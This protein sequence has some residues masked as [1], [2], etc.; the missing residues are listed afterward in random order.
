MAG[1]GFVKLWRDILESYLFELPPSHL[2][3]ALACISMANWEPVEHWD[4]STK[5]V[6]PRG[7]F[8]VDT[9]KLAERL[10]LGRQAVRCALN[11][12]TKGGFTTQHTTRRLMI[13]SLVNY[14][15]YQGREERGN[16]ACNPTKTREATR[17]QPEPQLGLM[18]YQ[19]LAVGP[20]L[21]LSG[22][23]RSKEERNVEGALDPVGSR[24]SDQLRNHLLSQQP[25]HALRKP[26]RW[27]KTRRVWSRALA[28]IA[29]E[30]GE[31]AITS[32]LA[33][34]FGDQGGRTE[35]RF[36]VD[37]PKA[38]GEKWD[39]IELAMRAPAPRANGQRAAPHR[40]QPKL[41]EDWGR[42]PAATAGK[43]NR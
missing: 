42:D 9:R 26:E 3:V 8:V 2:K 31:P 5:L 18:G 10:R 11:N 33:W 19:D 30:R 12:L 23:E 40:A 20:G 21:A 32:L 7:S 14:E 28:A 24:L 41:D 13:V 25:G 29:R 6:V 22:R 34:V 39:R 36:R 15:R 1:S 43:E 16:P 27:R 17:R 37:S 4:G 35:Y 38:L